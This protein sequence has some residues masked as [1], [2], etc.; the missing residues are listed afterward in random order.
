MRN[1]IRILKAANST[2][3]LGKEKG[4]YWGEIKECLSNCSSKK[5]YFRLLDFEQRHSCFEVFKGVLRQNPYLEETAAYSLHGAFCDFV[6]EARHAGGLSPRALPGRTRPPGN[7]LS[8]PSR[9]RPLQTWDKIGLY[10]SN[11][12]IFF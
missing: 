12:L 4:E 11:T 1:R 6:S 7:P 10:E 8:K 3:L 9:K 2:F 5:I